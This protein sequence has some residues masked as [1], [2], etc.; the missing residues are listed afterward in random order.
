MAPLSRDAYD[1][2]LRKVRLLALDVDGVLT[3]GQ[4]IFV[5]GDR[6]AKAFSVKDGSAI[7]IAHLLGLK[8]AVITARRSAVVQRRFSELP[9]DYLRQGEKNKVQACVEIQRLEGIADDEVAYIGD[10]LIDLPL[11]EHAGVGI[12]VADGHE[13]LRD[14]V[15][16]VTTARG[17]TGAAREVVDDIVTARG[18][19]DDVLDDYRRKQ[20]APSAVSEGEPR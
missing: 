20:H 1:E 15:D 7:F 3:G 9:V 6:E 14:V 11:L 4:I 5:D 2:R 8:V 17:G 18:L 12:T 16:W 19:W 13:K 10:D